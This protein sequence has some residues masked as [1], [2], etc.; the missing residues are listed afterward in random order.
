MS[1]CRIIGGGGF[2]LWVCRTANCPGHVGLATAYPDLSNEDVPES[3]VIDIKV[4][5]LGIGLEGIKQ[6]H[7]VSVVVGF[8]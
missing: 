2:L 3:P 7:P 8:C 5:A 1:Y 4:L 6:D